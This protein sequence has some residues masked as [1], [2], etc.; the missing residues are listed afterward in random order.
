M[1]VLGKYGPE[2]VAKLAGLAWQSLVAAPVD[3]YK[4]GTT[5]RLTL[6]TDM[7]GGTTASNPTTVDADGD[8]TVI[9][10]A[11]FADIRVKV[12]SSPDVYKTRTVA[13]TPDPEKI[14]TAKTVT[15]IGD[16][17]TQDAAAIHADATAAGVNGRLFFPPGTYL[18]TGLTASVAGQTWELAPGAAIKSAVQNAPA[19]NVTAADV[20][21]VG[22][23]ID[24]NRPAQTAGFTLARGVRAVSVAGFK[25]SGVTVTN[26]LGVGVWMEN[27]TN[28]KVVDCTVKDTAALGANDAQIWVYYTA[29]SSTGV[30]IRGCRIDGSL[31]NNGGVKMSALGVGISIRRLRICDN[32]ILVGDA[33]VNTL[34]IE[35]WTSTSG[36]VEDSVISGNV[37]IGENAT[38]ANIMGISVGGAGS[39]STTGTQGI[40]VTGNTVRDCRASSI[41]LLGSYLTCTGNVVRASGPIGVNATDY[42]GGS[43][44]VVVSGNSIHDAVSS[45]YAIS[46]AGAAGRPVTGCVIANNA[47]YNPAGA[48]INVTAGPFEDSVIGGN[49]LVSG[50]GA[51]II[52]ASGVTATRVKVAGN[53]L[54]L[55]GAAAASDG[56]IIAATTVG[57]TVENNTINAA[58]RT[59]I[60]GNAVC[61]GLVVRANRISGCTAD[62]IATNVASCTRWTIVDNEVT[63]CTGWGIL[64]AGATPTDFFVRDNRCRGNTAGQINYGAV[65][66]VALDANGNAVT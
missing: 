23:T 29:G 38:N 26:C 45:S 57:V 6:Y 31:Y 53:I 19:I 32:E 66:L 4:P 30:E 36:V 59:G 47:I 33:A 2:A 40:S 8:L 21:I 46:V 44:G 56:I 64:I 3:V 35:L 14:P 51:G 60:M 62:G 34:G 24:G 54:D 13:I 17:V 18:V 15:A 27:V 48:G 25:M 55:T 63:G 16:G 52:F 7:T 11:G 20:S 5:T 37:V 9:T 22:G 50:G 58:T 42:V 28:A 1:P 41:E 12:S 39:T 65:T 61:D 43:R 49:V 10:R